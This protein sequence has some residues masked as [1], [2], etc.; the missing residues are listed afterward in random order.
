MLEPYD[1]KLSRTV[2]RGAGGRKAPLSVVTIV[3]G[4][5]VSLREGF[6]G[7]EAVPVPALKE[8]ELGNR[9]GGAWWTA[10]RASK[11]WES[12]S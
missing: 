9:C 3:D 7:R 4:Q 6:A 5:S 8:R 10:R 2:L 1:G 12:G 11:G